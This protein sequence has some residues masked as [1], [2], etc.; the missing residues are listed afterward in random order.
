MYKHVNYVSYVHVLYVQHCPDSLKDDLC[1]FCH[2]L[3]V[4]GKILLACAKLQREQDQL[5][6]SLLVSVW[7]IMCENLNQNG[8]IY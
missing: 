5:Y 2:F 3:K 1:D 8:L 4:L 7:R 6:I